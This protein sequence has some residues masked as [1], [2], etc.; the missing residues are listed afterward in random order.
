VIVAWDSFVE[1][2]TQK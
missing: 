1:I 2:L